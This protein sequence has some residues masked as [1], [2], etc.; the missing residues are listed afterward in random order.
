MIY[1]VCLLLMDLD[2]TSVSF[3]LS[4]P[5]LKRASGFETGVIGDASLLEQVLGIFE[6]I[7]SYME[8]PGEHIQSLISI[9]LKSPQ[10]LII[11]ME[12]IELWRI[13]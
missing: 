10:R 2:G 1:W 9:N 12:T 4:H 6:A 8:S 7:F 5:R 11:N 13:V 3:Y